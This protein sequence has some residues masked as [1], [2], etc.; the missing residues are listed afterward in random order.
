[1]TLIASPLF[2]IIIAEHG[3]LS[4]P[5]TNSSAKHDVDGHFTSQSRPGT[6]SIIQKIINGAFAQAMGNGEGGSA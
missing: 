6:L 2:C 1:L 5:R 3:V 4:D